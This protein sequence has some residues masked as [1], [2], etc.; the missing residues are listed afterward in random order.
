ML[1]GFGEGRQ[2]IACLCLW[3]RGLSDRLIGV[4]QSLTPFV[5]RSFALP[6]ELPDATPALPIPSGR[7][8]GKPSPRNLYCWAGA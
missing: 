6:A 2:D 3:V 4:V 7:R 1:C 5:Y 8:V